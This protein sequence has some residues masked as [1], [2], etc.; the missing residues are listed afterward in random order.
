MVDA[1][2]LSK[3]ARGCHGALLGLLPLEVW[4]AVILHD[5]CVFWRWIRRLGDVLEQNARFVC[6]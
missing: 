2:I 1:F 3:L 6:I 5:A 4:P